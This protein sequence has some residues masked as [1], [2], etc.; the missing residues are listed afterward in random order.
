MKDRA[1]VTFFILTYAVS[2]SF[3]IPVALSAQGLIQA[4][5]PGALYYFASFGPAAAAIIVTGLSQG[6]KG[7]AALLGR[8][9]IWRTG[10][11]W[12]AA[13][14]LA[15]ICLFAIAVLFNRVIDGT[16]PDLRL[17][18]QIDYIP[19]TGVAGVLGL[20]FLTYGLGEEIGW[21]GFALPRLQRGRPAANA[22]VLL[23]L[24]WAGWHLPAFFFRDTYVEMGLPGFAMFA[25]SICFASV[26]FT[27]LYNGS[28]GS[29]LIAI[30][31]HV[32]FNWLSVSEAGG[33]FVAI[34]M[35]APIVAWAIFVVRRHGPENV[36]P[37]PKCVG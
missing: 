7:I 24:L 10:W 13:A 2:W 36:S 17:L 30:L 15:P 28:G 12:Y 26:V 23:G 33:R 37:N 22:A 4:R 29:I 1:L 31:F 20:W 18:G 6:R 5:I 19:D 32:F 35:S 21:R 3:M 34:I 16:W 27:W 14:I 9:S 11:F 8:L 25:V